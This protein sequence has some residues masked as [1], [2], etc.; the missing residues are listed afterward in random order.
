MLM[1]ICAFYLLKGK[2]KGILLIPRIG[3]STSN[4]ISDTMLDCELT[5][6]SASS[7]L[8]NY[9]SSSSSKLDKSD[10]DY[11]PVDVSISGDDT[12]DFFV[13]CYKIISGI[14]FLELS[15]LLRFPSDVVTI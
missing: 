12:L 4:N 14:V 8:E 6:L 11:L 2:C 10:S 13:G 15:F 5:M 7:V 9:E 1:N 3:Y